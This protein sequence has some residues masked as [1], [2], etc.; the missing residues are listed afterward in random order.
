M[1]KLIGIAAIIASLAFA[2]YLVIYIP[3]RNQEAIDRED[4]LKKQTLQSQSSCLYEADQN[5]AQN[6]NTACY[7]QGFQS[8]CSLPTTVAKGFETH[9]DEL[10]DTCFKLYPSN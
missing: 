1:N 9:R 4:L 6:W 8:G 2:Y 10:R 5:Y 3:Q 7:D